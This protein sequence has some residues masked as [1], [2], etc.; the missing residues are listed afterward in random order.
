MTPSEQLKQ[1]GMNLAAS[2]RTSDLSMARLIAIQ[3]AQQSPTKTTNIDL[4][5]PHLQPLG[6]ELGPAAGSLFALPCWEFTG[7]RQRSTLE[8]NHAREIK[9]WRLLT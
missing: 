2:C 8:T 5:R 4:V 1:I 9:I 7:M 6:I 3:L